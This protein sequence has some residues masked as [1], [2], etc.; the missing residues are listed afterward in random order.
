MAII[1]N[2]LRNENDNK[3]IQNMLQN[4]IHPFVSVVVPLFNEEES[5]E[6]LYRQVSTALRALARPYEIILVDDGSSDRTRPEVR[7]ADQGLRPFPQICS[8]QAEKPC[9]EV[10]RK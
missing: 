9:P 3:R 8:S 1:E 6:P 7:L 10:C 2:C 4:A 5:V